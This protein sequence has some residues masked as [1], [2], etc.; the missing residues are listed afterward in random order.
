MLRR[1]TAWGNWSLF[2]SQMNIK[3]A[4][5]MVGVKLLL[6]GVDSTSGRFLI[7]RRYRNDGSN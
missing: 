5:K 2:G 1:R 4:D 7:D 6:F 3:V